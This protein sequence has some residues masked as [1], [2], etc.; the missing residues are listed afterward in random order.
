[1]T[2]LSPCSGAKHLRVVEHGFREGKACTDVHDQG[3]EVF[4]SSGSDAAVDTSVQ[5]QERDDVLEIAFY[6]G[7]H[8]DVL[9]S[10]DHGLNVLRV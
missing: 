2:N 9:A 3:I 5:A 8:G 10:P 4:C 1:M 6:F 7:G